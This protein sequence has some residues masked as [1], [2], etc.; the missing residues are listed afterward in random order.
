MSNA[1]FVRVA[2]ALSANVADQSFDISMQDDGAVTLVEFLRIKAVLRPLLQNSIEMHPAALRFADR[3][4][5]DVLQQRLLSD[6]ETVSE[7]HHHIADHLV[8]SAGGTWSHHAGLVFTPHM[9]HLLGE[10]LVSMR[11]LPFHLEHAKCWSDCVQLL[12]DLHFL[13]VTS[14][15]W[16]HFANGTAADMGWLR[17]VGSLK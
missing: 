14:L 3:T 13:Q 1:M 6:V 5:N 16:H 4:V 2:S 15:T 9:A 11:W 7:I 10:H 17:L 8:L 12:C